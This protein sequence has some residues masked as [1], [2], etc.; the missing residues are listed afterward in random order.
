MPISTDS[1]PSRWS[2][3]Q[4]PGGFVGVDIFFV[5]SGYLITSLILGE[6]REG[7]FSLLGFYERRI[8]RIFPAPFAVLAVSSALPLLLFLPREAA[9]WR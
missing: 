6:M 9:R 3:S 4:V 1:A 7:R 2:L 5:I 8:P